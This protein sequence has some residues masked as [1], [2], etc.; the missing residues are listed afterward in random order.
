MKCSE[1][2]PGGSY[3]ECQRDLGHSGKHD[4]LGT[5]WSRPA[6]AE[7]N[8][9]VA[10]LLERSVPPRTFGVDERSYPIVVVE[11]RTHIVWVDAESEDQ[12]LAYWADDYCDLNLDSADTID[13]DL[14]FQRPDRWQRQEA[15]QH[16]HHGKTVGPQIACPDCGAVDV[17]REWFH[18]PYRKCHGPIEWRQTNAAKLQ[19]RY[20]REFK[21]TPAFDAARKQVAA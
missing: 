11:T 14:E 10:D 13:G 4:Y 17:R 12:A 3:Q 9:E 19:W 2:Y 8:P 18:N 20:R 16:R 7:P 1:P 21:A 5:T 15:A 6:A